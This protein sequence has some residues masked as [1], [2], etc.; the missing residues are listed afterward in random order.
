MTGVAAWRRAPVL[1]VA[2]GLLALESAGA[3]V[4]GVRDVVLSAPAGMS[5]LGPAVLL[6]G[7]AALLAALSRGVAL[8]RRWCRGP[9]VATQ[10]LHLPVAWAF[11]AAE[12]RWAAWLLALMS[13][14]IVFCLITRPATEVI[15][16]E[17]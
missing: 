5:L 14:A 1:A 17:E 8:G 10:I 12:P 2:A 11:R 9:S 6:L 7:Y 15:V 4:F 3:A 16:G 13:V